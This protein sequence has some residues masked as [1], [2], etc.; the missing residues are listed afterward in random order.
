MTYTKITNM[1]EIAGLVDFTMQNVSTYL[2][3]LRVIIH[4]CEKISGVLLHL[5]LS[6]VIGASLVHQTVVPMVMV[7]SLVLMLIALT[8]SSL[9]PPKEPCCLALQGNFVEP[10]LKSKWLIWF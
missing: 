5:L 7:L 4:V 10:D 1:T 2:H 3:P 6:S 8:F 9:L